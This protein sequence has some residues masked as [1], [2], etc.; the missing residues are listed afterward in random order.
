MTDAEQCKHERDEN[1]CAPCAKAQHDELEQIR[2]ALKMD[3]REFV[4]T[5]RNSL[6]HEM[7]R[8]FFEKKEPS[9]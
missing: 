3:R 4:H 5:V 8:R 9:A 6:T 2:A 7:M 1:E